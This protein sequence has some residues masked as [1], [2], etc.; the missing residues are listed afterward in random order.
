MMTKNDLRADAYVY[1]VGMDVEGQAIALRYKVFSI[2][3]E[4]PEFDCICESGTGQRFLTAAADLHATRR[5]AIDAA[6]EQNSKACGENFTLTPA[7][8][9]DR[10]KISGG[11]GFM[12]GSPWE[13]MPLRD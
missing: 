13:E 4:L 6:K 10:L 5:E 2:G 8:D 9:E 12:C 3:S 7:T 1:A 11:G